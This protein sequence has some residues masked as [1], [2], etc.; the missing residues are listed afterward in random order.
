MSCEKMIL[1]QLDYVFCLGPAV[2]GKRETQ[3]KYT[4][5]LVKFRR[6]ENLLGCLTELGKISTWTLPLPS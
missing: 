3:A 2:K 1:K 4:W 5:D 6:L